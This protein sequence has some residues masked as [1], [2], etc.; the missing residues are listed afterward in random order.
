VNA[1]PDPVGVLVEVEM[2]QDSWISRTNQAWKFLIFIA[3]GVS[4][5]LVFLLLIWRINHEQGATVI[6]DEFGLAA[7]LVC[8]GAS[9]FIWFL[10][11][12]RCSNCNKSVAKYVLT[13]S[14]SRNWF[15]AL[16]D[17]KRC[18]LCGH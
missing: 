7:L 2:S 3:G 17:L 18:P 11:S 13:S 4:S 8:L 16:M 6:P 1:K 12:L 14:Q 10:F 15:S 5:F 9:T